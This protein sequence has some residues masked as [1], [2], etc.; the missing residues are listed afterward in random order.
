MTILDTSI[1]VALINKSDTCYEKA[2]K[3]AKETNLE[4]LEIFDYTYIETLTVLRNKVSETACNNFLNFVKD[5]QKNI[6]LSNEEIFSLANAF[7]FQDKTLSF[8]DCLLIATAKINSA[9][10]LTFDKALEKAWNKVKN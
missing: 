10:L 4:E 1:W 2:K 3:I 9:K 7:F 5:Y 8:T 6:T